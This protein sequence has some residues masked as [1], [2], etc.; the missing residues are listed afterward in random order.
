MPRAFFYTPRRVRSSH[1][2]ELVCEA[3]GLN[4]ETRSLIAGLRAAHFI[5][6]SGSSERVEAYHDRIRE[7]LAAQLSP[8][9]KG[10][11][12]GLVAR[13]LVARRDRRSEVLFDHY[14]GA[15]DCEHASIQAVRAAERAAA[16]LAFD[17]AA[18]FYNP[19]WI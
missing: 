7:A 6:S 2:T 10:R 19:R 16:A 17:R 11:I 1:G 4:R 8:P 12:H 18:L 5:R 14:R 15:G 13:T 3:A 9:D